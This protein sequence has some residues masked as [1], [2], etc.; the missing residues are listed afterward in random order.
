MIRIAELINAS[1]GFVRLKANSPDESKSYESE[2]IISMVA[3][4][5]I[6]AHAPHPVH[7]PVYQ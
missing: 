3:V 7:F 5:Q 4:G 6:A 2:G 1:R